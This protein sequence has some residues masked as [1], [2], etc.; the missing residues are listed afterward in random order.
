MIFVSGKSKPVVVNLGWK[1]RLLG[2][3]PSIKA[4][5]HQTPKISFYQ[6]GHHNWVLLL[7]DSCCSGDDKRDSHFCLRSCQCQRR[8]HQRPHLQ[9]QVIPRLSFNSGQKWRNSCSIILTLYTDL[10]MSC[11]HC[12]L[13]VRFRSTMIFSA[14]SQALKSRK[15]CLQS[16]LSSAC[17]LASSSLSTIRSV[18][19]FFSFLVLFVPSS[20]SLALS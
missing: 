5:K 9:L 11:H 6:D 17:L 2:L 1:W 19:V 7:G 3:Q 16:T 13:K 12:H 20:L 8:R 4:S 14:W 10:Y 18:V 15:W